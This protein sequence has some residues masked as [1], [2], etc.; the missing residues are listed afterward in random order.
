[1]IWDKPRSGLQWLALLIPAAICV[2]S[3]VIGG[4][5][6]PKNGDWIP[7]SIIGLLIASAISFVQSIWLARV[8]PTPAGKL[9]CFAVCFCLMMLVNGAV[10]F[11]GCAAGFS[12]L[13]PLKFY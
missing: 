13:S 9:G 7:W 4:I 11:A 3:T 12:L 5:V 2:L 6:Q 1:M 8:N 10:S